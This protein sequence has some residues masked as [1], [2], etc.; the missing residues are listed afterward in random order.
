M[1]KI[2]VN[3]NGK[4]IAIPIPKGTSL[5]PQNPEC[6]KKSCVCLSYDKQLVCWKVEVKKGNNGISLGDVTVCSK[7]PNKNIKIEG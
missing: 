5:R 2:I 6:N 3:V 4:D 1:P 7:N